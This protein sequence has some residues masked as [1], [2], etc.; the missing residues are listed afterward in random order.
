MGFSKKYVFIDKLRKYNFI[1][2][3]NNQIKA[4]ELTSGDI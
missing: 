2:F 4:M 1:E 3:V